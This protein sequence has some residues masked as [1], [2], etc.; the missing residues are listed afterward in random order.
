MGAIAPGSW[1]PALPNGTSLGPKP[2]ALHQ[3]YVDLNQ[4][5]ADAW[6]VTNATSL[7]DYAPGTS[8][9]T[10][11]LKSWPPESPPC[12]LPE[13]PPVKPVSLEV[14]Q[15]ACGAVAGKNRKEDCVFDVRVT[16]NTGF[17]KTYLLSQKI[18]AGGTGIV[19]SDDK[20]PTKPEEPVTFTAIV[21]RNTTV[22]RRE[23][24][25]KGVLTGTVQF[26][27]DGSKVGAPVKLD[28]KGRATW[29]T[30]RLKVGTHRVAASYIPSQGSVF[31][32]STS[33]EKLHSVRRCFC[34]SAAVS[35]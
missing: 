4:Q 34:E 18:Q 33:L 35:K 29:E 13:S 16:A 1:L 31:L 20:D 7:F 10:F 30:S 23:L 15:R 21:V 25:G 11:T 32:A 28:S 2:A 24:R 8:T 27:L 6:R 5:F 9:A 17:A 19:V 22:A 3:R 12:V 26:T 14:A